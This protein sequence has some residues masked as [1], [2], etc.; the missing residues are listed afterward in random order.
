VPCLAG[1]SWAVVPELL[2]DATMAG[3]RGIAAFATTREE[4]QLVR[5]Y[6][7]MSLILIPRGILPST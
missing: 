1:S 2:P 6:D 5:Q 4:E 7:T 3:A